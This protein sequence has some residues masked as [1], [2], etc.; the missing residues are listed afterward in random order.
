V[1]SIECLLGHHPTNSD[2]HRLASS[3]PSANSLVPSAH[4][5]FRNTIDRMLQ[6]RAAFRPSPA[7]LQ[8]ILDGIARTR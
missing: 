5:D 7:E 1:V 8:E 4:K 6:L 3:P 2:Q